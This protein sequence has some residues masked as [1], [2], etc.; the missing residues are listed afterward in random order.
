[1][2]RTSPGPLAANHEPLPLPGPELETRWRHRA[3]ILST[4][5]TV[6]AMLRPISG[7]QLTKLGKRLARPGPI[8]DE[9]YELL[10]QV[11]A[12]YQTVTDLLQGRL[13]GLGFEPTTRGF[14]STGTLVDKLRRTNLS[15]KD[16]HDLGGARILVDGGRLDQDRATERI[17]G[18]FQNCPKAPI[19]IDRRIE[20]S[21]GYRAVHV[22]V[23]PESTPMEIQVRTRL[24][25]GW[26][27][28]SEK[29]G[30]IWGRGLRYGEG[31]DLP[32]SPAGLG[33]PA[34]RSQVV[35]QLLV[36]A[37]TI[38]SVESNEAE[39]SE[40]R[41]EMLAPGVTIPGEYVHRLAAIE[42]SIADS[43]AR[44]QSVL[45]R[46]LQEIRRPGGAP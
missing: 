4:S 45:D 27:Q 44:A 35:E 19:K 16:I 21:H 34:T 32:D 20:P 43:K 38:D 18:E 17:M 7:N 1:M 41:E 40:I 24:Q 23:Y 33:S 11:A 46:M 42:Q 22:I 15:L 26:A 29:L 6:T 13:R 37:D 28:I 31:P 5:C 8:S 3:F 36:L 14:K 2:T 9:D 30:D 10:T 12:W 39:L 25:D